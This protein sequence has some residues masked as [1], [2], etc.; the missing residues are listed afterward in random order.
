ML[1]K[2]FLVSP[3]SSPIKKCMVGRCQWGPDKKEPEGLREVKS[4]GKVRRDTNAPVD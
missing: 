1:T 3:N 2:C 4:M